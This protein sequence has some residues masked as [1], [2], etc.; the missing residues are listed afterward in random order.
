MKSMR[1]SWALFLLFAATVG[2]ARAGAQ[3]QTTGDI[4]GIVTDPSNAVIVG[5]PV[6][7]KSTSTGITQASK[8]GSSGEYRFSLLQPGQYTI[9]VTAQGFQPTE[10]KVVVLSDKSPR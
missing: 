9:T 7:L 2:A 10:R 1:M 5:V 4:A 8:T 6:T 3:A